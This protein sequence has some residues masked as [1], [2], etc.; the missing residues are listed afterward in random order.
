MKKEIYMQL[1]F[2]EIRDVSGRNSIA[3]LYRNKRTGIYLLYFPDNT[4]YVGQAV[5]VV[6][7]FAQHLKQKGTIQGISFMP[8]AKSRLNQVERSCIGVL[9]EHCVLKNIA[10]V[11]SPVQ[12]S[13][14]DDIITP[15]EQKNWLDT[16]ATPT[17]HTRISD[18]ILGLRYAEKNKKLRSDQFFMT[19]ILPVFRKYMQYCVPEPFKTEISFWGCSCLPNFQNR[20]TKIYSRLN[21]YWQEVFTLG[22]DKIENCPVFSFHCTASDI[23]D[24]P[25]K[26]AEWKDKFKTFNV[27]DHYYIP[28]GLDQ[29][30]PHLSSTEETLQILDDPLFIS[31]IKKFN[32]RN[33]RKGAEVYSRYHCIDLAALIL[34]DSKLEI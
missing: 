29:C 9:E 25:R 19:K 14:I 27:S 17:C 30:N 24:N 2:P 3:D 20:K 12:E 10:L 4:Y 8:V 21:I 22:R 18:E 11:N 1:G 5:D 15:A 13:D 23:M 34:E 16:L 28:G 6:R 32:L 26:L 33:M 31:A 7:R